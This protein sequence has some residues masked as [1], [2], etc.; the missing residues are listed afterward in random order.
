MVNKVIGRIDIRVLMDYDDPYYEIKDGCAI[1]DYGFK[2][3]AYEDIFLNLG[4]ELQAK[5]FLKYT[6]ENEHGTFVGEGYIIE[7]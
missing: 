7:F 3:N 6:E 1:I 4:G 2:A 5:E